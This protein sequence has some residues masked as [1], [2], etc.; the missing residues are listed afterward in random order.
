MSKKFG[1][2]SENLTLIISKLELQLAHKHRYQVDVFG[3]RAQSRERKYSDLDL[4]IESE[5]VFT[6]AELETLRQNFEDSNLPIKIDLVT[7]ETVLSEYRDSILKT[8]Q[9]WLHKNSSKS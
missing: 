6:P 7:P 8:K 4:W 2:S 3:S 5:P 1:L 9:T